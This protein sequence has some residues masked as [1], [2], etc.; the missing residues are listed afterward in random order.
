MRMNKEGIKR[1]VHEAQNMM[2]SWFGSEYQANSK[3][4]NSLFLIVE[5]I[6]REYYGYSI[7]KTQYDAFVT[8]VIRALHVE[9]KDQPEMQYLYK[10]NLFYTLAY[11]F[12]IYMDY[13]WKS[14]IP[15]HNEPF[16]NLLMHLDECNATFNNVTPPFNEKDLENINGLLMVLQRRFNFYDS[17]PSDP[18]Y[19]R[20]SCTSTWQISKRLNPGQRNDILELVGKVYEDFDKIR[21][22]SAY[23][24]PDA[25][26][27]NKIREPLI[28]LVKKFNEQAS[29]PT[30]LS[31]SKVVSNPTPG[32]VPP[33]SADKPISA[34]KSKV[35]AHR[36][37][38]SVQQ[39]SGHRVL[40]I[41]IMAPPSIQDQKVD[42]SS[43][44]S[45]KPK[46]KCAIS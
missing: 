4:N 42:G 39:Q 27:L 34:P 16:N 32:N 26:D 46:S 11:C 45:S 7:D 22:N 40:F 6:L 17:P 41:G 24:V 36:A 2:L 25:D 3:L 31:E 23:T 8:K 38:P 37:L 35:A 44:N 21:A 29:K 14:R 10:N 28:Q 43:S 30:S 19:W 33:S 1:Y 13:K 18:K 15:K 20:K 9:I 12:K 5:N